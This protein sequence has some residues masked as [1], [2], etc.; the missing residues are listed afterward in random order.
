[1]QSHAETMQAEQDAMLASER[2]SAMAA[3]PGTAGGT[4]S[5]ASVASLPERA[6]DAT[7]PQARKQ[8]GGPILPTVGG[9]RGRGT[10]I[11][12]LLREVTN[13]YADYTAGQSG[14]LRSAL[15]NVLRVYVPPIGTWLWP[16][17][18]SVM[19]AANVAAALKPSPS[20]CLSAPKSLN[21]LRVLNNLNDTLECDL[22]DVD[23]EGRAI[24]RF[25]RFGPV[26]PGGI[27]SFDKLFN[28]FFYRRRRVCGEAVSALAHSRHTRADMH[29]AWRLAIPI[30]YLPW[31]LLQPATKHDVRKHM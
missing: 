7:L 4:V 27:G 6:V 5:S 19:G 23:A 24:R 26:G 15:G 10:P 2:A 29:K 12:P 21:T 20:K 13:Q 22:D 16:L 31:W 30:A 9:A 1:M 28:G 11:L 3:A 14:V 18:A 17:V 8:A 25:G